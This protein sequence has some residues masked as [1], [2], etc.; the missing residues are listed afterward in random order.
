[1]IKVGGGSKK[2]K[3][4]KKN[5]DVVVE[6][7]FNLDFIMINKFALLKVSPPLGPGDLDSKIEI[8]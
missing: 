7:A 1:M 2:N 3:G 6:E 5:K 8:L 4:K